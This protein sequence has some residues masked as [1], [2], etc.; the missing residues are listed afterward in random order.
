MKNI[1]VKALCEAPRAYSSLLAGRGYR[2]GISN[3]DYR[4]THILNNP[5]FPAR[6]S[7]SFNSPTLPTRFSSSR[8]YNPSLLPFSLLSQ[9]SYRPVRQNV[10]RPRVGEALR[11]SSGRRYIN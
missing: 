9:T 2:L 4:F 10:R 11:V 7:A 8:S 1:A 6:S 5:L 3:R